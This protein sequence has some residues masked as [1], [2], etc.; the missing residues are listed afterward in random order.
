MGLEII[1]SG[2]YIFDSG[3]GFFIFEFFFPCFFENLTGSLFGEFLFKTQRRVIG[4]EGFMFG[5]G[6]SCLGFRDTGSIHSGSGVSF[7][8]GG[9]GSLTGTI[10]VELLVSG[11]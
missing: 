4:S 1:I 5:S 10:S 11:D 9:V 7:G 2:V 8:A 3:F 6:F